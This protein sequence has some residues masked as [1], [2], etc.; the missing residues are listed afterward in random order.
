[1]R[2]FAILAL[3]AFSCATVPPMQCFNER[4][5]GVGFG[6][7]WE[8]QK[9]EENRPCLTASKDAAS[10][11]ACVEKSDAVA[12]AKPAETPQGIVVTD[13]NGVKDCKFLGTFRGTSFLGGSLGGEDGLRRSRLEAKEKAENY[14]A[15]HIVWVSSN[16][17]TGNAKTSAEGRGYDCSKNAAA[18]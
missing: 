5:E 8:N 14:G 10:Y 3:F 2:Y 13:E 9:H 7:C 16:I 18:H 6:E 1:M 12:A 17:S 11:K 15:S 4:P